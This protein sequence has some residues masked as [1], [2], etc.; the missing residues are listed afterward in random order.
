MYHGTTDSAKL[1]DSTLGSAMLRAHSDFYRRR[2]IIIVDVIR[3]LIRH[4]NI[5]LM[6]S[7]AGL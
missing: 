7:Q 2:H 4:I 6:I 5:K 1:S 3:K